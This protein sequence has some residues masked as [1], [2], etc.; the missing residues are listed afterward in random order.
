[1]TLPLPSEA[2]VGAA[3]VHGVLWGWRQF[4]LGDARGAP[5]AGEPVGSAPRIAG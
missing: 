4:L 3:H 2:I 5:T 1:V